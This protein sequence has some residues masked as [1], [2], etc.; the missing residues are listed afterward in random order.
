MSNSN[1][2][3]N[4]Q[5]SQQQVEKFRKQAKTDAKTDPPIVENCK[6]WHSSLRQVADIVA[7]QV[8]D[9]FNE[10]NERCQSVIEMINRGLADFPSQ[11]SYRSVEVSADENRA[12]ARPL[13]ENLREDAELMQKFHHRF[14]NLDESV[15]KPHNPNIIF[16]IGLAFFVIACESLANSRLFASADDFGIVGGALLAILVSVGNVL[17]MIMLAILAKTWRGNLDMPMWAYYGLCV[18]SSIYAITYNISV[19]AFRNHQIISSGGTPNPY[20]GWILFVIGGLISGISFLDG[21]K[22]SDTYTKV[23]ECKERIKKITND[24]SRQIFSPIDDEIEKVRE[25]IENFPKHI[26]KLNNDADRWDN[27]V[28]LL[29]R[30]AVSE[31]NRVWQIYNAVYA[32]I[33]RDPDPDLP[34]LTVDNAKEWGIHIHDEW[35]DFCNKMSE[36]IR[37]RKGTFEERSDEIAQSLNKLVELK[38]NFSDVITADIEDVINI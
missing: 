25:T 10:F 31:V 16:F 34:E 13:L 27:N 17:P 29:V 36:L 4:I 37:D 5:I 15:S 38:A 9:K 22:F 30:A 19:V 7:W 14:P 3:L 35:I 2:H 6:A 12:K 18:A 23:R 24:Y 32:P 11:A 33:H 26:G 28:P 21:W 20:E 8:R 1:D